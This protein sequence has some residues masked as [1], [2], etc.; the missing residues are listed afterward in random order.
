MYFL[1]LVEC[2]LYNWSMENGC[3]YTF[4]S[5]DRL[6]HYTGMM[7]VDEVTRHCN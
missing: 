1:L 4:N 6:F 7:S 2:A 3:D 5:S